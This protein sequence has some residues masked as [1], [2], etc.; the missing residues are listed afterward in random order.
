MALQRLRGRSAAEV[1]GR[2]ARRVS[3]LLAPIAAADADIRDHPPL[4]EAEHIRQTAITLKAKLLRA[5]QTWQEIAH[6]I[7][8][9]LED[10]PTPVQDH[11]AARANR[12]GGL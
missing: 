4:Q 9:F 8:E 1:E 6:E 2:A 10:T 12:E 7:D 3:L 5:G 11:Y